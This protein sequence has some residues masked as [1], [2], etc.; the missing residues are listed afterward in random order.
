MQVH[1]SHIGMEKPRPVT[2]WPDLRDS[3]TSQRA[4][5]AGICRVSERTIHRLIASSELAVIHVRRQTRVEEQELER[6]SDAQRAARR[7]ET[8]RRAE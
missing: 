3:P 7:V 8:R 4:A 5:V 1:R 6:W 2:A